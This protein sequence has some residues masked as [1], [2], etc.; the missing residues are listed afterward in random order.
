MRNEGSD[1]ERE[2]RGRE[3]VWKLQTT[4]EV[5]QRYYPITDATLGPDCQWELVQDRSKLPVLDRG[6][7]GWQR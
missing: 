6:S 3:G 5:P 2:R 7:G 4:L 1:V